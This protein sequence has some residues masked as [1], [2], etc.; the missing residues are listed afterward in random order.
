M[1]K[2]IKNR[3][4]YLEEGCCSNKNSKYKALTL[5]S[6]KRYGPKELGGD[7]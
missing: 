4:W 2:K 7:C 6:R 3:N 5:G 1:W